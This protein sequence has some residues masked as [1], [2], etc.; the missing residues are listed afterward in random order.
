MLQLDRN[1]YYGSESASLN[2]T[3]LWKR[4]REGATVPSEYGE[5]RD[6][7]VDLIPKFV[8]SRI[9]CNSVEVPFC[10]V[11]SNIFFLRGNLFSQI[12]RASQT[13]PHPEM[14]GL[15]GFEPW[16]TGL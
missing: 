11:I 7:N 9:Q 12:T 16:T 10:W 5:N 3:N 2:L 4:F 1:N 13:A 15:Q 14:V 6:W 8:K